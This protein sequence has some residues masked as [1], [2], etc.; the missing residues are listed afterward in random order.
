MLLTLPYPPSMNHYWVRNPRRGMRIS[1]EGLAYRAATCRVMA[2]IEGFGDLRIRLVVGVWVPDRRRRD[3]DNLWKP[4]L[5]S[6]KHGGLYDDDSQ[7]DH[8]SM[9]R[10]GMDR[11]NPRVEVFAEAIPPGWDAL[12]EF[13]ESCR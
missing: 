4:L 5:D 9:I 13:G 11:E 8:E 1:A 3:I 10:V 2:G 12:R 6:L 7:V